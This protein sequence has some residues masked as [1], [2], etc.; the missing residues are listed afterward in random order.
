MTFSRLDYV[1][2]S[3]LAALS[4]TFLALL[5]VG[6]RVGARVVRT[7]PAH[8]ALVSGG[9]A[10]EIEFAQPMQAKDAEAAFSLTPPISGTFRWEG[11]TLRF[12]PAVA[13]APGARYTAT[14]KAGAL[15]QGGQATQQALEWG[16]VIRE[17]WVVYISP[18]N[19]ERELARIAVSGGLSQTLTQTGG[20]IYDFA[21]AP[22]GA[23]IA[24]SVVNE[25]GGLDLWLINEDG[26][27]TH[28]LLDCGADRCYVPAW[29]P[30][31]DQ[32][33]YSRERAGVQPGAPPGPPRVW[34]VHPVTAQTRP[35]LDDGQILGYGPVWS[36]TG[37]RIAFYDG[38]VFGLRLYDLTARTDWVLPTQL[39]EL[40]S[41]SPDGAQMLY[42]E[43]NITDAGNQSA[44]Y[45]ADFDQR[46][47]TPAL[48]SDITNAN[49]DSPVWS[50]KGEWVAVGLQSSSSS[51][52]GE[53]W[54]MRPD[55]SEA[56]PIVTETGY[57]YS[58]YRWSPTGEALVFHRFP[59]GVAYAQPDVVVWSL[60]EE[61]LTVLAANATTPMWLP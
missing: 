35:L 45:L 49:Y 39:G 44:A 9:V 22:D 52:S 58:A 12:T 48:A 51:A 42:H 59:L 43:L 17:P 36:P 7:A 56:R 41:W 21:P 28:R 40:G 34:V 16:F 5:V 25:Q 18:A 4:L 1:V 11:R 19:R 54:L 26:T 2:W 61:R 55:G 50:P 33:A 23:S 38:S 13:L 27:N 15:S 10:I 46:Q 57:V 20:R 32:I 29:S 37:R 8:D 31:S 53:L 60:A 14:L 24:Y 6:D 3:V 47:V 30:R